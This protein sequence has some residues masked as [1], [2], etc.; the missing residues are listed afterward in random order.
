MRLANALCRYVEM[1]AGV[2][3][4]PQQARAS[5]EPIGLREVLTLGL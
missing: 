1:A 3:G 5:T 4:A 2:V